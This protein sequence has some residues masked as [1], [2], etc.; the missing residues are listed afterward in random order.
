MEF[1]IPQT[2]SFLNSFL[3]LGNYFRAHVK[4]VARLEKPLRRLAEKYPGSKK[5]PWGDHPDERKAFMDLKTAIGYCPKLFYYNPSMPVFVHTDACNGGIGG[6]V[7]QQ[8]EDGK[9]YPVGFLS[10]SLHGSELKWSTFEQECYAIHQTLKKYEYLL[11]DV[12]FTI[13][14]ES[15]I[16]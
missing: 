6:Y 7:F 3:G 14:T 15:P 4:D 10:K 11:R 5:I 2:G 1:K 8:D 13:R 12:P 9:E 16:S